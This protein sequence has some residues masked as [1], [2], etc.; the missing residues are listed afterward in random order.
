MNKNIFFMEYFCRAHS[1]VVYI[2]G[3]WSSQSLCGIIHSSISRFIGLFYQI[4]SLWYILTF[5]HYICQRNCSINV[6]YQ[7]QAIMT[8]CS[9]SIQV[10][11]LFLS[12]KKG[13]LRLTQMKCIKFNQVLTQ[14]R[15]QSCCWVMIRA[16]SSTRCG[17]PL[18]LPMPQ[19]GM[20]GHPLPAQPLSSSSPLPL[21]AAKRP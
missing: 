10:F 7:T 18:P 8:Y 12:K 1:Y 21:S 3:P 15:P 4:S 20:K 14:W 11:C 16:Y 17:S 5:K 2:H 13:M 19:L 6:E 9:W